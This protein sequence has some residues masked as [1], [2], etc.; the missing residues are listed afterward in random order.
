[1]KPMLGLLLELY[2]D[3]DTDAAARVMFREIEPQ[4][5]RLYP[6]TFDYND[7]KGNTT[8]LPLFGELVEAAFYYSDHAEEDDS[9]P[10]PVWKSTSVSGAPDSSSL[11]HISAMTRPTW[12]GRATRNQ[13]R[14]AIEQASRR[15]R[16]GRRNDSA[17]TRRKILISTQASTCAR[18]S[19][20][21]TCSTLCGNQN[22]TAHSRHRRDA[23]S[24]AWRC[25]FLAARPSQDGRVIA[26]E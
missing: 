3:R 22:F 25:W 19:A 1:M 24:M 20:S 6:A 11:N 18:S 8:T 23:C 16:G 7:G 14:H 9:L 17:R 15:W 2:R 13:H 21:S 12:L 26:E 4:L 5:K 10:K